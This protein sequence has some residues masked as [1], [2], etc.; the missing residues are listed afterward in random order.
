VH[1]FS[2]PEDQGDFQFFGVD[3]CYILQ[4]GKEDYAMEHQ[5]EAERFHRYFREKAFDNKSSL[6]LG[7]LL[8]S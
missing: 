4:G 8:I 3:R 5:A 7:W 1:G 2:A 6:M